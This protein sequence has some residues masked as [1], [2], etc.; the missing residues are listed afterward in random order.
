[1]TVRKPFWENLEVDPRHLDS[2]P[3]NAVR[4]SYHSVYSLAPN[5]IRDGIFSPSF[6]RRV[7]KKTPSLDVAPENEVSTWRTHSPLEDYYHLESLR[8][9][10]VRFLISGK[11]PITDDTP[12]TPAR[13]K[14]RIPPKYLTAVIVPENR[15]ASDKLDKLVPKEKL[16]NYEGS[17]DPVEVQIGRIIKSATLAGI[18]VYSTRGIRIWPP[19]G[20]L[21]RL[22]VW[23]KSTFEK[24]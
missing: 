18:P 11:A 17:D 16:K 8:Y 7:I 24:K 9:G 2:F 6:A 20:I 10:K 3:A 4:W 19:V 13:A 21:E 14:Y 23:I 12:F 5:I 15:E 1:M 22:K